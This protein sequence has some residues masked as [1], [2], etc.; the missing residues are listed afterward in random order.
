MFLALQT[1][2]MNDVAVIRCQGRIVL[3]AEAK[4]N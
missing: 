4:T 2:L 1:Q 3:G